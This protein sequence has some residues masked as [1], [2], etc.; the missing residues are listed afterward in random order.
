VDD[1]PN[2]TIRN[3]TYEQ[4]VTFA[5]DIVMEIPANFT[6]Y[7]PLPVN[8]TGELDH[9]VFNENYITVEG[10]ASYQVIDTQYGKALNITGKGNFSFRATHFFNGDYSKG[11]ARTFYN[12]DLSLWG[13]N[14]SDYRSGGVMWRN[15]TIWLSVNCSEPVYL[16]VRLA[17]SYNI[18][19]YYKNGLIWSEEHDWNSF[20]KGDSH[21]DLEPGVRHRFYPRFTENGWTTWYGQKTP[22]TAY[23]SLS[24][25]GDDDSSFPPSITMVVLLAVVAVLAKRK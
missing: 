24:G 12:S 20:F 19:S 10:N 15:R 2:G 11:L 1:K 4:N 3:E 8:E 6:I 25:N 5:V 9:E 7:S 23:C 17:N 21:A 18:T 14:G 22:G 13:D 16:S